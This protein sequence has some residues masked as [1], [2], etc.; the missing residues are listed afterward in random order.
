MDQQESM[1]SRIGRWFRGAPHDQLPLERDREIVPTEQ[2]SVFRPWARRD[3]AITNL[4]NGF[5]TLTEL[6]TTIRDALQ[7]Q[8]QRQDELLQCLSHLPEALDAIPESQRVQA[9]TLKTL[10]QQIQQQGTQQSR[11]TEILDK[12]S[13]A[14]QSQSRN[15]DALH[16]RVDRLDEHGEAISSNLRSVGSAMQTVSHNSDSSAQVLRQMRDNLSTRDGEL[17]RILHR[18]NTRFTTLLAIAIFLSIA[19]LAAVGTV[20]YLLISRMPK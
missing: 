15:L 6:M 4:Q 12:V 2:T 8:S 3:A 14:E 18:Q 11:L 9:E 16:E 19:A 7:K 10:C 5:G 17:E 20:G 1:L 13:E